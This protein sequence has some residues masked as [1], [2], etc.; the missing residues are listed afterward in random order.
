MY[1]IF[2]NLALIL[3]SAKFFA[4]LARKCR[5]PQVVGEIIAGL[6]I[7]PCL[8]DLV[9]PSDSIAIFA[10]I[11]V[12]LLMFT[13][14]LGTNLQELMR[15]GPIATLIA[16]VGVAVPLAG[17]TL[18]Y[19]LFY[20]F[21]AL[22][23]PEFYRA[24]FIGTIM[25]ATSVS[26]TV[27]TLQELGKLKSFLGTTIV[28]MKFVEMLNPRNCWVMHTQHESEFE[29]Y[30][31]LL[32]AKRNEGNVFAMNEHKLLLL[33]LTYRVCSIFSALAK[34]GDHLSNRKLE[35]YMRLM[36]LIDQHY[37]KERGVRFYADK[38][39]LSPKYLTSIVKSVSGSS[40]QQ[41]VFKAITKKAIFL[42]NNTDKSI[43]EISD[44]LNFP[45]ASAFG[46]FFKK[47]VGMSPVNYRQENLRS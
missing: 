8:L 1:S 19:S 42:V 27:A 12:V 34:D 24:L 44:Y 32:A 35:T 15:A 4:L 38:L 21:S 16:C 36:Q 43:K 37:V 31:Q 33:A 47:Q 40:V 17:G 9:Q 18:L 7:G 5:A 3:I 13:T 28:G 23:S 20:G 22:G 45:N 14:G 25:T 26:I 41:L 10:E 2:R 11:G 6:V 46:T 30:A 29:K 39:C